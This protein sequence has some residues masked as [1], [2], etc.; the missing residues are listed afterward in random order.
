MIKKF[1]EFSSINEWS[2]ANDTK[3]FGESIIQSALYSK[4][5]TDD[6][7]NDDHVKDIATEVAGDYSD[8]EEIGSSDMTFI[9]KSFLDA[10]GKKTEWVNNRLTVIG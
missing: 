1:K 3:R 2:M 5:I 10:I 6:E 7:A 4:F 8:L 9:V